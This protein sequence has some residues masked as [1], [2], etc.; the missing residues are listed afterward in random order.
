MG[1]D[2]GEMAGKRK[3]SGHERSPRLEQG[4]RGSID[5]RVTARSSKFLHGITAQK[6]PLC[7]GLEVWFRPK[8]AVE[9]FNPLPESGHAFMLRV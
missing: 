7:A 1:G 2:I 6:G 3:A 8:S 5:R 4:P 9:P